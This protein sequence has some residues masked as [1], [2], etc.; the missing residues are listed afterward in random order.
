MSEYA[1]I[2]SVSG[3]L[4]ALFTLLSTVLCVFFRGDFAFMFVSVTSVS[5][6][7]VSLSL[8]NQNRPYKSYQEL[9]T[10]GKSNG[11]YCKPLHHSVFIFAQSKNVLQISPGTGDTWKVQRSLS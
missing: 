8:Y 5:S 10:H 11:D 1:C 4:F 2:I 7:P 3:G 6:H 9:V